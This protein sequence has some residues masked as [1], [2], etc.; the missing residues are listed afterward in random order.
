MITNGKIQLYPYLRV[1]I[2]LAVGIVIGDGLGSSVDVLRACAVV[3]CCL[4]VAC[5]G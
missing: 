2:M 3:T 1:A 4:L 5:F